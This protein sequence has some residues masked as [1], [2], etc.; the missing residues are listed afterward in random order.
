M[1]FKNR[2]T[3]EY[4]E[5]TDESITEII[6]TILFTSSSGSSWSCMKKI[7]GAHEGYFIV[8]E[9]WMKKNTDIFE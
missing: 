9:K 7:K 3:E 8:S 6:E 1:V 5:L 2:S 4:V